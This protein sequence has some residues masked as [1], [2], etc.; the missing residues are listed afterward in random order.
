M[1]ITLASSEC[2][3]ALSHHMPICHFVQRPRSVHIS[4]I[5]KAPC[6]PLE[7]LIPSNLIIFTILSWLWRLLEGN[8]SRQMSVDVVDVPR[9]EGSQ[10]RTFKSQFVNVNNIMRKKQR[11]SLEATKRNTKQ[12]QTTTRGPPQSTSTTSCLNQY[13]KHPS[14]PY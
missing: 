9:E 14:V 12:Q 1:T 4:P 6:D 10:T 8:H 7:S 13:H 5:L 11:D 3:Q 2:A